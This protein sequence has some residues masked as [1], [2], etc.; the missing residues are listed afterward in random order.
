MHIWA[1]EHPE[2][3]DGERYLGVNGFGPAQAIVDVLRWHYKG[4]GIGEKIVIGRSGEGYVGFNKET[5]E[6]E[7]VRYPPENMKVDGSKAAREMGVKYI[8]FPQSIVDT[9]KAMEPLL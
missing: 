8:S 2:K 6:V 1:F 7:E 4:T 9:A 5:G 3:S